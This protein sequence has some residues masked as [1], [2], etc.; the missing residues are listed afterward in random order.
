[1]LTPTTQIVAI[2]GNQPTAVA[3]DPS[4]RFAYVTN[5]LDGTVSMFV[6]D[7]NTGALTPNGTVEAGGEPFRIEFDPT[8][9]FVYVANEGSAISIYT[10]QSDGT[11]LPV[12]TAGTGSLA[13]VLTVPQ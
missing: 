13:V 11:L 1:M 3:V 12:E 4:S 5:R 8:G 2:A 10:F 6:I 7:S 9:R